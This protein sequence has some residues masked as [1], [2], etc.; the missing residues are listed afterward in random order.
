RYALD[1]R[2][3]ELLLRFHNLPNISI[4]NQVFQ[5]GAPRDLHNTLRSLMEM[6]KVDIVFYASNRGKI[7]DTVNNPVVPPSEFE[8]AASPALERALRGDEK[9]DTVR[10]A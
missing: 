4:W 7:L 9:A 2:R 5:S 3:H 10:V 6:Q 1:F 8:T